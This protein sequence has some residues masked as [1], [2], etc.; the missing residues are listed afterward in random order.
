MKVAFSVAIAAVGMIQRPKVGWRGRQPEHAGARAL[1]AQLFAIGQHDV[2]SAVRKTLIS[3]FDV[4]PDG[5]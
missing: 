1:P 2:F 5:A 4:A 3:E